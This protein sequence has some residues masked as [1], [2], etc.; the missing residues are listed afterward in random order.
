VLERLRAD[1]HAEVPGP[2]GILREASDRWLEALQ[3]VELAKS[4][5]AAAS[6]AE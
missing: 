5:W 6:A 2:D 4:C 3:Y 1:A